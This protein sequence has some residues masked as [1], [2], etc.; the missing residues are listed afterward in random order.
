MGEVLPGFLDLGR[1]EPLALVDQQALPH[2]GRVDAIEPGDRNRPQVDARPGLDLE[3]DIERLGL[4]VQEGLRVRHLGERA[5]VVAQCLDHAGLGA[6]DVLGDGGLPGLEVERLFRRLARQ[7][8][9]DAVELDG[10]ELEF[11]AFLHVDGHGHRP[12]RGIE[13]GG[14]AGVVEVAPGD[15][16]ADGTIVIAETA[17]RRLQPVHVGPRAANERER[18]DGR[19]F[20]QRDQRCR[21]FQRIIERRLPGWLHHH[22]IGLRVRGMGALCQQE[23]QQECATVAPGPFRGSHIVVLTGFEPFWTPLHRVF[24]PERVF[25]RRPHR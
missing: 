1:V 7:R 24:T 4:R 2:V 23:R 20:L 5:A 16:D 9:G 6:H 22:G 18:A 15:A 21:G 14:Q 13:G 25:G 8:V 12:G 10:A 17:E 19:V 11:G 3:G